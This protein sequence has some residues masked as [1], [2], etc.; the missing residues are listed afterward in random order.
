MVAI[1]KTK[2]VKMVPFRLVNKDM[3]YMYEAFQQD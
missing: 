3:Y 1:K 2:L